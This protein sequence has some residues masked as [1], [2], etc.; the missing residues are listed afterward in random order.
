MISKNPAELT[1]GG[2]DIKPAQA[3]YQDKSDPK[4][5]YRLIDTFV[6]FVQTLH[7]S[8]SICRTAPLSVPGSV[9]VNIIMHVFNGA[10]KHMP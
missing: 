8:A 6:P 1:V 5:L 4:P 9:E 7:P 3:Q 10:D 2:M